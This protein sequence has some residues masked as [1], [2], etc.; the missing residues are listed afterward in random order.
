MNRLTIAAIIAVVLIFV[1]ESF[2]GD[3][4]EVEGHSYK[5]IL[6][7]LK[8]NPDDNV[9]GSLVKEYISD[10]KITENESINFFKYAMDKHSPVE[11]APVVRGENLND[12]YPV[13]E[14]KMN[15]TKHI[16]SQG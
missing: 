2:K 10:G 14:H 9:M 12:T 1:F 7:Q 5:S 11:M 8:E 16:K 13:S 3:F 4:I 15:L 6:I